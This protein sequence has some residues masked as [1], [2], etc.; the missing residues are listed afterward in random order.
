MC[1]YVCVGEPFDYIGF[2]TFCMDDECAYVFIFYVI[3]LVMWMLG[4]RWPIWRLM[5][6]EVDKMFLQCG[7]VLLIV[8]PI[9]Q[10]CHFQR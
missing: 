5:A 3:L 4:G 10:P 2:Y 8:S 7:V 1:M 9:Y 6:D